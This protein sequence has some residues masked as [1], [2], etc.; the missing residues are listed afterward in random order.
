MFLFLLI[1]Y[2]PSYL[3]ASQQ[4]SFTRH[5]RSDN[6]CG[7]DYP[8]QTESGELV[9]GH[10]QPDSTLEY[11]CCSQ[12]GWC[13]TS[14]EHCSCGP[15]CPRFVAHYPGA[16]L[17]KRRVIVKVADVTANPHMDSADCQVV[18]EDKESFL[19]GMEFDVDSEQ[20]PQIVKINKMSCK[21][22]IKTLYD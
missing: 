3:A 18:M 11:S 2:H 12:W 15:H 5:W 16:P 9:S 6:R 4:V 7:K 1:L 8:A 14:E 19:Q 10:C 17:L 13:G 22:I 21:L 20:T